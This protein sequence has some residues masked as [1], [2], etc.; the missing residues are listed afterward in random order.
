MVKGVLRTEGQVIISDLDVI[1]HV[2][3][4][5]VGLKEWH[6]RFTLPQSVLLDATTYELCLSDGRK[7]KIII[8]RVNISSGRDTVVEF[9]GTGPLE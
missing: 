9:R 3:K 7:G 6:G 5:P 2:Y 1:V 8:I 4:P